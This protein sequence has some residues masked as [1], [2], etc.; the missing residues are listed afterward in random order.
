MKN[1]KYITCPSS[2]GFVKYRNADAIYDYPLNLQSG[3]QNLSVYPRVL[4]ARVA[5]SRQQRFTDKV[6]ESGTNI[7]ILDESGNWV[8]CVWHHHEDGFNMIPVPVHIHDKRLGGVGHTGGNAAIS[9]ELKGF[10][11]GLTW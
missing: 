7:E 10:F 11:N 2:V 4:K 9:Q 5:N 1:L 3:V 8:E 6:R